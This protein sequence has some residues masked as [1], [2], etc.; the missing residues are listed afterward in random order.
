MGAA[1]VDGDLCRLGWGA[2]MTRGQDVES[3]ARS[4]SRASVCSRRTCRARFN[5]SSGGRGM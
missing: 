1:L 5:A 2:A 4:A 3:S